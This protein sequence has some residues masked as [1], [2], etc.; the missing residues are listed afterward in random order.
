MAGSVPS[1][2]VREGRTEQPDR[3]PQRPVDGPRPGGLVE[4]LEPARR[5][6]AGVDHEQVEPAERRDTRRRRPPRDHRA[7]RGPPGRPGRRGPRLARR[8]ARSV[9][10][11]GPPGRPRP[12]AP[13]ATAPPSPP[14]PPPMRARAPVNPRSIAPPSSDRDGIGSAGPATRRTAGR[15]DGGTTRVAGH[16]PRCANQRSRPVVGVSAGRHSGRPATCRA[17]RTLVAAGVGV[18]RPGRARPSPAGD[19]AAAPSAAMPAPP[20]R[21]ASTVASPLGPVVAERRGAPAQ[22]EDAFRHAPA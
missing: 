21:H 16:A 15:T 2:Q 12:E 14:L 1:P 6:T 17:R 5:R 3:A 4:V 19:R 8:A 13:L 20:S 9:G 18:Q 7:S 22:L 11:R 10:R